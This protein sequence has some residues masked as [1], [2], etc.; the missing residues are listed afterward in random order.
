VALQRSHQPKDRAAE[1]RLS[2][3]VGPDN[4]YE[5]AG[6]NF[7]RDIIKGQH[8]REPKGGMIKVNDRRRLTCHVDENSPSVQAAETNAYQPLARIIHDGS[9]R[10]RAVAL[11]NGHAEMRGPGAYLNSTSRE[12][13]AS[14]SAEGLRSSESAIAVEALM[15]NAA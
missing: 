12:Q 10:H 7:E 9:S 4:P 2:G 5:L 11:R 3:P 13:A 1:S 15:N 14:L 6:L 8:P